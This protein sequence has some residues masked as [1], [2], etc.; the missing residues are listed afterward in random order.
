MG[1]VG[2]DSAVRGVRSAFLPA[3]LLVVIAT[4]LAPGGTSAD[5]QRGRILGKVVSS[6]TGEPLA[7][8][9]IALFYQG[10]SKDSLGSPV[11]GATSATDGSYRIDAAPGTY[12]LMASYISFNPLHVDRVEV[13]AGQAATLNLTLTPEAIKMETVEITAEALKTSE[14]ALLSLQKKAPAVG[15]AV[16]QEQIAKTTDSNAAEVLQRVTGLSVVDDRFVYVRGLGE[17]YS[18][19]QV[20]GVAVGTPEPNKRVLPLD[21]FASGVI[22]NVVVQKTYTADQPGDFG[23][24]VVNISTRD[25]PGMKVWSLAASSGYSDG[26]T[27]ETFLTY[28]GGDTDFLGYDDGTRE[29]P[30]KL[31]EIA[32][33]TPVTVQGPTG[34][35]FAPD[36]LKEISESFPNTWT[37]QR[38][39]ARPAANFSTSY[40]DEVRVLGRSLGFNVAGSYS[41]GY[42]STREEQN[43]F[44]PELNPITDYDI[45][46]SEANVLW[47]VVGTTSYRLNKANTLDLRALYNRSAEDQVT[48]SEGPNTDQSAEYRI[49]QLRYAERG[50]FSGSAGMTH[51][52]RPVFGSTFDWK[53][54]Y[55]R[56]TREEPDR[57]TSIY[58]KTILIEEEDVNGNGQL[59]STQAWLLASSTTSTP[60]LSRQ[61][62]D[63]KDEE[64]S[65]DGNWSVPFR[66]WGGLEAKIKAGFLFSGKD[67][68]EGVRRFRY[69][70]GNQ[71]NANTMDLSQSPESLLVDENLSVQSFILIEETRDT[72]RYTA[73]HTLS[74]QYAILDMPLTRRLRFLPGLRV[75]DSEQTVETYTVFVR[76]ENKVKSSINKTDVLPSV[77]VTYGFTDKMNLRGAFSRTVNRPDLR[78]L[79]PLSQ[80]DYSTSVN[81]AGNPDLNRALLTNYDL[82]W[83]FYPTGREL[84]AVSGFY[85]KIKDP[86]EKTVLIT[87]QP[88]YKPENGEGGKLYGMEIETRIGLDRI[89]KRLEG[90]AATTNMTFVDSETKILQGEQTSKERPLQGQSPFVGNFGLFYA[91]GSGRLTGSVLYNVFGKRLAYVGV[92]VV[93]DIYEMPRH[94]VDA[95]LGYSFSPSLRLRFAGENLLD[96]EFRFE[97]GDADHVTTLYKKG[98]SVSIALSTGS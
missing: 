79:T 6:E 4:L 97:Q 89:M 29:I 86:I 24:G 61:Y 3:L 77:N 20:N 55:S 60:P 8:A 46:R 37:P 64:R 35:G 96:D 22:D 73:E 53:V 52:I 31:L 21:M 90:F 16:G 9:N 42:R 38:K 19:T 94:T 26:S 17:R 25:F 74:A 59:D 10:T 98:R 68:V 41:R 72:D 12:W 83:E 32:G 58:Q 62:G 45:Q 30:G 57:R 85:K 91:S 43:T 49:T 14:A 47:G 36:Q 82:R 2:V 51:A 84:L 63:L 5:E 78:E 65:V 33:D 67:R 70:A 40:G 75:E 66:Q 23:G 1:K 92:G 88:T 11:G 13:K 15:D 7:F 34:G 28:S 56:A 18:S 54:N 93:P 39:S 87:P 69:R 95:T 50:L 81:E 71:A 80:T 76:E 44:N 48:F 27:G